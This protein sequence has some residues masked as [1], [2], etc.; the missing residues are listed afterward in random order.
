MGRIP[1]SEKL[2]VLHKR[3]NSSSVHDDDDEYAGTYRM[4]SFN[5]ENNLETNFFQQFLSASNE[6]INAQS[7]GKLY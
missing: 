5:L 2:S 3:N 4:I 6:E 7:D 1:K